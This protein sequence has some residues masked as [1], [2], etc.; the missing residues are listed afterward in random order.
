VVI[1]DHDLFDWELVVGSARWVL[2]TRHR[3]AVCN[4]DVGPFRESL[5]R[6]RH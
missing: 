3:M 2:D 4:Q 5:G 6:Q 1:T